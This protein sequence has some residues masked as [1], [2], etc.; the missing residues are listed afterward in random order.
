M[1]P[2]EGISM[3]ELYSRDAND[4]VRLP[5]FLEIDREVT[6]VS[7]GTIYFSGCS[8]KLILYSSLLSVW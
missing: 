8:S 6:K 7:T 5:D 4:D 1:Q 2:N 3:L